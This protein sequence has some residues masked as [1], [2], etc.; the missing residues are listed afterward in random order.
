MSP[1]P[2]AGFWSRED[3]WQLTTLWG[4]MIEWLVNGA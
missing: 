1:L 3:Q 2:P 4:I